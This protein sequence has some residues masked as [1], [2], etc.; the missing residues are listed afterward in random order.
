MT[1]GLGHCLEHPRLKIH[2]N[3]P[4]CSAF[5][6]IPL[7]NFCPFI[8]SHILKYSQC[9]AEMED[10]NPNFWAHLRRLKFRAIRLHHPDG[11]PA[12]ASIDGEVYFITVPDFSTRFPQDFST[13]AA[14]ELLRHLPLISASTLPEDRRACDICYEPYKSGKHRERP[15]RL[16]CQHVLGRTCIGKWILPGKEGPNTTCP[17]CRSELF[18]KNAFMEPLLIPSEDGDVADWVRETTLLYEG[19]PN[20]EERMEILARELQRVGSTSSHWPTAET[21]ENIR[22]SW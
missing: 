1:P 6:A 19:D 13:T 15:C 7:R 9:F 5:F 22:S 16:P 10:E 21:I 17:M 20:A 3:L 14:F 4:S 18:T 8:C 11:K 2:K 12:E